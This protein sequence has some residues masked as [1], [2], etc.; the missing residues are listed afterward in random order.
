MKK[1]IMLACS[2]GMSTSLLVTKML[3]SA[4]EGGIDAEIF[5]VSISEVNKVLE[6]KKIDVLLFGPQLSYMKDDYSNKLSSKG[7]PVDTIDMKD[8]G[9]MKGEKVLDKALQIIGGYND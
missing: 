3:K 2:A 6:S 4:E 1:V 7:I 8:Y 5:A 9:L